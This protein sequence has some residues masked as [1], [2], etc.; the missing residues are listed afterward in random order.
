MFFIYTTLAHICSSTGVMNL[1]ATS[2]LRTKNNSNPKAAIIEIIG[3]KKVYIKKATPR[4]E[5]NVVRARL[6][7]TFTRCFLISEAL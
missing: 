5:L 3:G 1:P 4:H 2:G 6:V 7:Y